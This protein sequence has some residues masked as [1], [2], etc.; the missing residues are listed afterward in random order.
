MECDEKRLLKRLV[1]GGFLNYLSMPMLSR[2]E[3]EQLDTLERD[4]GIEGNIS[5]TYMTT[6]SL[7]DGGDPVVATASEAAAQ[8]GASGTNTARLRSRIALASATAKNKLI[9][10]GQ[11]QQ[12][13]PKEKPSQ[14]ENFRIFF[15]VL[16]KDHNLADLIWNQQTRRELRI[17]LESERQ[18]IYREAEARGIENIAWNH[19]Q[20]SVEYPSLVNEVKVGG[21]RGVYMR[22]WLQAGDG[23]IRTWDEPVRLFEQLFRRFLCESDRNAKVTVMCVRCLER[24]YAI[25]A[26]TIGPFSDAMILVRSMGTTR[27]IETQHRLLG[28]V[29]TILG[30]ARN[31]DDPID[32]GLNIPENA[33]QLLNAE[34]IEQL[35]QFV[36][37]GHTN[38]VQVGNLLTTVLNSNQ[39]LLTDGTDLGPAGPANGGPDTKQT[40][41]CAPDASCPQVWFIASTGR[42]PPPEHSIR[43]PFRVSELAAMMQKGELSPFDLV[44][45][46]HVESYDAEEDTASSDVK[47]AQIDTGKW[48][49]LEQGTE[50]PSV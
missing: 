36:A 16:T 17:A 27:S 40:V 47:E 20:F 45:T 11:Q 39:K 3:E 31:D 4:S 24:L 48:T 37:W 26:R 30:V 14:P 5:D 29:A 43:G 35:C 12:R 8:T 19:Q 42:I 7:D 49:R 9:A 18:Y 44:T 41:D 32:E 28:L 22:L 50:T 33:E 34:S 1:P 21:T 46:T 2:M 6:V 23:F 15:H 38:G 10:G 13:H 25:H